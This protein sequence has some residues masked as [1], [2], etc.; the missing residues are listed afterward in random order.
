VL[1]FFVQPIGPIL[2]F[3]T[4][5][6]A[7]V[8]ARARTA[9]RRSSVPRHYERRAVDPPTEGDRCEHP[10]STHVLWEPDEICDGWMHCTRLHDV[11]APLA[12]ALRRSGDG[13]RVA[14]ICQS[15]CSDSV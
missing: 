7:P 11:L 15:A 5:R 8:L 2:Y 1:T 9:A 12:E 4:G 13:G 14:Q 10:I 3:L 6:R